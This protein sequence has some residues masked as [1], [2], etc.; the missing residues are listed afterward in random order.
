MIKNSPTKP[1]RNG[2]PI[3]ESEAMTKNA[4]NQGIGRAKPPKSEIMRVWRRS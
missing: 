4:E 3:D 1:F 2:S